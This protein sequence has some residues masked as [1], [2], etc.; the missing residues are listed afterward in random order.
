[1]PTALDVPHAATPA[2]A[3]KRRA[4][5]S[6]DSHDSDDEVEK[7]LRKQLAELE[8][9]KKGKG[10]VEVKTKAGLKVKKEA[11]AESSSGPPQPKKKKIEVIYLGDDSD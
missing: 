6:D 9:R 8:T 2:A 4:Y 5:T 1:M 11:K 3:G 7:S 10:K